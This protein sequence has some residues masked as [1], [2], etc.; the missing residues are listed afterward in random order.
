MMQ[1]I[2][3]G[4]DV[5]A[6]QPQQNGVTIL[7][8]AKLLLVMPELAVVEYYESG[9]RHCLPKNLLRAPFNAAEVSHALERQ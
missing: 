1:R 3:V 4:S 9:M 5:M 6:P 8:I 7:K 2:G